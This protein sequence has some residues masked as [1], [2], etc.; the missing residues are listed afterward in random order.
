MI[1]LSEIP[2]VMFTVVRE[3]GKKFDIL[4]LLP[5]FAIDTELVR[6]SFWQKSPEDALLIEATSQSV[7]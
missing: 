7:V 6:Q 5:D 1:F 4:I 3:V 2:I